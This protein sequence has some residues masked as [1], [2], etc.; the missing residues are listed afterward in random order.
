MKVGLL[1]ASASRQAGGLFGAISSLVRYMHGDCC[2]M[3]VFA[4]RDRFSSIDRPTWGPVPLHLHARRGPTAFSYTPQLLNSLQAAQLDVVH[5]HGLWMYPSLAA[6]VW[7]QRCGKRWLVSPHGMLDPWAVQNA[8]WKKRL[9]DL[10]YERRHLRKAACLHALSKAE[11]TAFRDYGL[12]NPIAVIPNGVEVPQCSITASLPEWADHLPRGCRVLLFLGRL[13]PKKGLLILL[14]AW[15]RQLQLSST[16]W[17]LVVGGWD[18][19]N[20]RAELEQLVATLGIGSSVR[21]VGA[22]FGDQKVATLSLAD[23]FVLP[24]FSEGLPMA[25]LEAWAYGLPVLMTPACNLPEGFAAHAAIQAAPDVDS[26]AAGLKTLFGMDASALRDMGARGRT[27]VEDQFTWQRV[28]AQ[29]TD[30]Y[31]WVLGQTERPSCVLLD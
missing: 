13:H 23:A 6:Q 2:Q 19:N 15:A 4:G 5:T 26:L 10:F 31:R 11:A 20:H 22:Q 30:V 7:G 3:Q 1:T 25:V 8:R 27:L 21:F 24:S 14:R 18:Q 12:A 29:M 9:A 28:A 17:I 16:P